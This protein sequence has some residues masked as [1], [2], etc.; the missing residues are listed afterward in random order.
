VEK[1]ELDENIDDALDA[2][3]AG[4]PEAMRAQK[5]LC[6]LWEEAPLDESVRASIDEF[7]RAYESDAPRRLVAA[8]RA[9]RGKKS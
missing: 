4:D 9:A 8:F 3:L 1:K 6:R 5:R 7:A 2:L